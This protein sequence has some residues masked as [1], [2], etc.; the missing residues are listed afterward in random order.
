MLFEFDYTT[1]VMVL[2]FFIL[3]FFLNI[4]LYKPLIAAIGEREEK[5]KS[6]L[7]EAESLNAQAEKLKRDYDARIQEVKK[8]AAS[9]VQKAAEDGDKV[10]AE[11]I[12]AA[13]KEARHI[14]EQAFSD[15]EREHQKS[16][17]TLKAETSNLAVQIAE[18]ILKDSLD[19]VT[20]RAIIENFIRKVEKKN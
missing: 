2:N 9:I 18:K 10:K 4:F 1:L 3:L 16:R 15:I 7:D 5:I 12:E 20:Q 8:E 19:E 14:N 6:N 11:M 13:R 17:E